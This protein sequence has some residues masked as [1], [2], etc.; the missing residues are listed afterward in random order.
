MNISSVKC[1]TM[2]DIYGDDFHGFWECVQDLHDTRYYVRPMRAAVKRCKENKDPYGYWT[3]YEKI[4]KNCYPWK[5]PKCNKIMIYR[6]EREGTAKLQ[7]QTQNQIGFII[8]L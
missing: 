4:A 5:C 8:P 6:D 7:K 2:P 1:K 3:P